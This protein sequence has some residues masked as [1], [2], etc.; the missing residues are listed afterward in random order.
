VV[1]VIGGI[2]GGNIGA[3]IDDSERERASREKYGY[4]KDKKKE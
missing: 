3:W 1:A 2:I 4:E